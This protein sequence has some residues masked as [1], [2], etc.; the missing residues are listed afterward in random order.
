MNRPKPREIYVGEAS[1]HGDIPYSRE[2]T[3]ASNTREE[4]G[5]KPLSSLIPPDSQIDKFY[6]KWGG[7]WHERRKVPDT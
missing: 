5:H 1:R 2:V 7:D 3:L 6:R 4:F